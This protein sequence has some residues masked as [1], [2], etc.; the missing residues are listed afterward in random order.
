MSPQVRSQVSKINVGNER[1]E[2]KVCI[3]VVVVHLVLSK[4][5]RKPGIKG[6]QQGNAHGSFGQPM[7]DGGLRFQFSIE[8]GRDGKVECKD[9]A[10]K[11]GPVVQGRSKVPL[12]YAPRL[13]PQH[14]RLAQEWKVNDSE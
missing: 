10:Q 2:C 11:C 7:P 4:R 6:Y 8:Q 9:H 3:G 12:P 14:G 1:N 13:G 5:P